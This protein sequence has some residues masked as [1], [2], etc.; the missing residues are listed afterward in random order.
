MKFGL[1]QKKYDFINENLI[2]PL[3]KAGGRVYIFGSRS[4]GDHQEFSDIDISI[5]LDDK[6]SKKKIKFLIS[7]IRDLFEES[8]FPYKVDIVLEDDLTESYRGQIVKDRVE[9]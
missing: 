8:N 5:G 3:K 7:N 9:L 6:N 2:L 4:R 1:S